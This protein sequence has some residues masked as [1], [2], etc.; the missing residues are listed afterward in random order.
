MPYNKYKI[1]KLLL[2]L[3][4]LFFLLFCYLQI[5]VVLNRNTFEPEISDAIVILGHVIDDYYMP[6]YFLEERLKE[7]L[8][9]YNNNYADTIIVSGGIGPTDDFPVALGMKKW[10]LNNGVPSESILMESE[11]NNTYENFKYTKYLAEYNDI[12]SIIVVTNDF[13]MYRSIYIANMHFEDISGSAAYSKFSFRKLLAYLKEP[14]SIIK[15]T[16]VDKINILM[17]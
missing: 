3:L 14:L 7:G 9:L 10:L 1:I 12:S 15:Y 8:Y 11:S 4:S 17:T 2:I 16:V 13:H 5:K 6:S